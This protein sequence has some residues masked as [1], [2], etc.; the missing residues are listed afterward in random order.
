MHPH[1]KLQQVYGISKCLVEMARDAVYG[2]QHSNYFCQRTHMHCMRRKW[3]STMYKFRSTLWHPS[4]WLDV[5]IL[6]FIPKSLTR[7]QQTCFTYIGSKITGFKWDSQL[8]TQIWKLIYGQWIHHSK[9]K[10]TGEML[11]ILPRNWS[12]IPKSHMNMAEYDIH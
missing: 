5:Y 12:S 1:R 8:I 2:P 10:H 6:D 4:H 3:P 7:T 11:E 9:Y